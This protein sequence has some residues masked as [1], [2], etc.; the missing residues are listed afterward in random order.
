M[1]TPEKLTLAV[2]LRWFRT[3]YGTEF[4]MLMAASIVSAAPIVI[5]FFF[6]QKHFARGAGLSGIKS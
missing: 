5:V 3:Q 2:G 4:P 1:Q 6:A